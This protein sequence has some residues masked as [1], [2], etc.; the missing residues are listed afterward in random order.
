MREPFT[1]AQFCAI[2]ASKYLFQATDSQL[3]AWAIADGVIV[4]VGEDAY[5][6]PE[7]VMSEQQMIWHNEVLAPKPCTRKLP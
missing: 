6:Y 7:Q 2:N 5:E 3:L 1:S 4:K